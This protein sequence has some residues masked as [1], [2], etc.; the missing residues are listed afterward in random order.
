MSCIKTYF[1]NP[2][3]KHTFHTKRVD[4]LDLGSQLK[5][6]LESSFPQNTISLDSCH[7]AAIRCK[8][9]VLS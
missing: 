3:G 9:I 7:P 8:Q 6:V 5:Q 4:E 2:K 1:L